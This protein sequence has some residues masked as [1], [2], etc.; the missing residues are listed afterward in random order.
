MAATSHPSPGVRLGN[1]RRR[2]VEA[3]TAARIADGRRTSPLVGWKA[4]QVTTIVPSSAWDTAP[5][6]A[7]TNIRVARLTTPMPAQTSGMAKPAKKGRVEAADSPAIS[8]SQSRV[9]PRGARPRHRACT[10][11][12]AA[13]PWARASHHRLPHPA[14][15]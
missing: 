8:P 7:R 2:R 4:T 5:T 1:G 15:T 13:R 6:R 14:T 10:A 9:R 12:L 11:K 3:M